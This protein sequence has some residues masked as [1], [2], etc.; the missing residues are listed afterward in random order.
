MQNSRPAS[1][2]SEH[3]PYYPKSETYLDR[4]TENLFFGGGGLKGLFYIGVLRALKKLGMLDGIKRVGGTSVGSLMILPLAVGHD[5]EYLHDRTKEKIKANALA[6]FKDFIHPNEAAATYFPENKS[7]GFFTRTAKTLY[8]QAAGVCLFAKSAVTIPFRGGILHGS[9][10]TV[11]AQEIIDESPLAQRVGKENVANLTFGQLHEFQ[12]QFPDLKL[13]NFYIPVVNVTDPNKPF[14][15]ILSSETTPHVRIKDAIRATMSVPFMYP[16]AEIVIDGKVNKYWDGGVFFNEGASIF[17]DNKYFGDGCTLINDGK[18]NL[19][20]LVPNGKPKIDKPVPTGKNFRTLLVSSSA[21]S[22]TERMHAH[23]LPA[24]KKF[25]FSESAFGPITEYLTAL[26]EHVFAM[27][28]SILSALKFQALPKQVHK[29]HKSHHHRKKSLSLLNAISRAFYQTFTFSIHAQDEIQRVTRE[30]E[31]TLY[32]ETGHVSQFDYARFTDEVFEAAIASAEK[33]M[34][35]Y[36]EK[37]LK[38]R[39]DPHLL[40][41][42]NLDPR[43]GRKIQQFHKVNELYKMHAFIRSLRPTSGISRQSSDHKEGVAA[44]K[45]T[46]T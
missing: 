46:R 27:H 33:E 14:L 8:N 15:E 30:A 5:P 41:K 23:D 19:L 36:H 26:N 34:M 7:D 38:G 24:N 28:Q 42:L 18:L 29:E 22:R 21:Q 44:P 13:R 39:H 35:E 2:E 16:A 40:Q 9:Q 1:P 45:M 17:D 12:K 43:L 6:I 3:K 11:E 20:S 32:L 4:L 31:R 10:M 25:R 37:N